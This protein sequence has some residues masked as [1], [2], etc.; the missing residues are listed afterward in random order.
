MN[1]KLII[2]LAIVGVLAV[3]L[4]GLVSAQITI[5]S[6]NGTAS[7]GTSI[8]GFFGWVGRCFGYGGAPYYGS[9]NSVVPNQPANATAPNPYANTAPPQGYYSYGRGCWGRILP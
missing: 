1:T 9:Q 6:Q 3:A 2:A 8:N 4:V 7:G 5:P